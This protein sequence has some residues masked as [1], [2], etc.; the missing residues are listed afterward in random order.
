M[1][2]LLLYIKSGLHGTEPIDVLSYAMT[3]PT[4][5]HETTANQFFTESQLES[6]RM[7]GF[8]IASRALE[9]GGCFPRTSAT[10]ED[11]SSGSPA[12]ADL[13]LDSVI[14]KLEADIVAGTSRTST[15][16]TVLI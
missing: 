15:L 9:S 16:G 8:E 10:T 6:Y 7:L 1:A 2:G 14:K 11:T 12:T 13:T 5:P 3:H 4:F